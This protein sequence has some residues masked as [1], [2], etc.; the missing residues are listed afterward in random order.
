MDFLTFDE[1]FRVARDEIL[2]RNAKLSLEAV[3]REGTDVNAIVA[4]AAAVG[5]EVVGDTAN[6]A[7][8]LFLS[9][10]TGDD[11]DKWASDRYGLFRK[12]AA[13]ALGTVEFTTV[14][15][16]PATFTIPVN[17]ELQTVDGIKF[18][19][20]AAAIFLIG[21]T[22]PLSVPVRSA[23]AGAAQQAKANTITSIISTITGAAGDLAV[24]NAAATAG[25]ADAEEDTAFRERCRRFFTTAR[26]GTVAAIET[27]ALAVPGV[28]TAYVTEQLDA[29]GRPSKS[30]ELII[31]DAFTEALVDQSVNPAAYMA[32]SLVL[33]G[34]VFAGLYDFR[35]A[36]IFIRVTIASVV[37]QSVK[38]Q[39]SFRAG[40]DV[41][42]AAF[43][44]RA[45]IVA[46]VN[47]LS[48]GDV[49]DPVDLVE[50]L[51]GVPEL[52][53]L[54]DEI[55]SPA[56]KI[57]PTPLQVIRTTMGLV[58]AGPSNPLV[59]MANTAVS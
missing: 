28:E 3:E 54:G 17:T 39:L 33:A 40:V 7:S 6:L 45:A 8:A 56:G 12:A 25:A 15:A 1:L 53:V 5:D 58:N 51:R 16:A 36:G 19:T 24:N 57:I 11:L 32:Q 29:L 9:T 13:A 26:R 43:S 59:L 10:A 31:S 18:V 42:E 44:G 22:G 21:T 20:S 49:L 50:A 37:L 27:G 46:L 14:I 2:T 47:T 34:Q 55:I 41:D 52:E 38:L 30:V 4:A 48:P 35:A 23:L